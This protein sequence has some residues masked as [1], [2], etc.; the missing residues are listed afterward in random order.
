MKSREDFGASPEPAGVLPDNPHHLQRHAVRAERIIN[1]GRIVSTLASSLSFAYQYRL[2][3]VITEYA[4]NIDL[5]IVPLL[6]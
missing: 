1:S 6:S 3:M 4:G 5:L 2:N